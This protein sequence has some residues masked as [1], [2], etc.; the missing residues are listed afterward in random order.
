M[1]N[2]AWL[3]FRE[4]MGWVPQGRISPAGRLLG[5]GTTFLAVIAA[6]VVFRAKSVSS[7]ITILRSMAGL[8][9]IVF[10]EGYLTHLGLPGG[11]L[12]ND[13]GAWG[14]AQ[15]LVGLI[16]VFFL[17]NVRQFMA[18]HPAHLDTQVSTD[19][20]LVRLVWWPQWTWFVLI[21]TM[22]YAA[23][24]ALAKDGHVFL[25]YQF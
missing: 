23:M 1:V 16:I 2:H 21:L 5:V 18:S 7:A 14:W 15:I 19:Q 10:P 9:G 17:P 3:A 25:Y 24:V 4:R 11:V 8:N 13:I 6:W 12:K 20:P 22:F